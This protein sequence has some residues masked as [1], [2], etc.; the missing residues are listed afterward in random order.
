[1]SLPCNLLSII[2]E[3]QINESMLDDARHKNKIVLIFP[4]CNRAAS[5]SYGTKHS[6]LQQLR[7]HYNPV[8]IINKKQQQYAVEA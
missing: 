5:L 2:A 1:M 6:K 8:P 3:N 7:K 4:L